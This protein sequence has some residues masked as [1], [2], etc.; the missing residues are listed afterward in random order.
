MQVFSNDQLELSEEFS[1]ALKDSNNPCLPF[2]QIIRDRVDGYLREGVNYVIT[3]FAELVGRPIQEMSEEEVRRYPNLPLIVA[4]KR[5][6]TALFV[7]KVRSLHPEILDYSP[8]QY[9]AC[10]ATLNDLVENEVK[11]E[12]V[13]RC[14]T[15][16][17]VLMK[18]GL[19][20]LKEKIKRGVLAIRDEDLSVYSFA[21]LTR[22][23]QEEVE[24][25]AV[26]EARKLNSC[27]PDLREIQDFLDQL[28]PRI[29]ELIKMMEKERRGKYD[30][31]QLENAK[32]KQE[33]LKGNITKLIDSLADIARATEDSARQLVE[34]AERINRMPR[35]RR[36]CGI[37]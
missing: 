20:E 22:Q 27:L 34:L 32:K 17:C 4:V 24:E 8:E 23:S 33:E 36:Y 11:N 1:R 25:F 18:K 15:L 10:I 14:F 9:D 35:G 19:P 30:K 29:G 13:K 31:S 28:R 6:I 2:E 37:A 7:D 16:F 3:C 12:V 21:N 5:Q 26:R